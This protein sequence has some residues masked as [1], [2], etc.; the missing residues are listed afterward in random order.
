MRNQ[1]TRIC[2]DLLVVE[3]RLHHKRFCQSF[4]SRLERAPHGPVD[5]Q[6][7]E[8]VVNN[9]AESTRVNKIPCL[10]LRRSHDCQVYECENHTS[11]RL[12][13]CCLSPTACAA[14]P[15]VMQSL[16]SWVARP[17]N[18]A[19]LSQEL[20]SSEFRENLAF[21]LA[22]TE[23]QTRRPHGHLTGEHLE[24]TRRSSSWIASVVNG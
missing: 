21:L 3:Y 15:F 23:E 18:S 10:Q 6:G 8:W 22:S 16:T 4:W 7:R 12:H 11:T 2:R 9:N 20:A 24:Y 5:S 13:W 17:A 14:M 19:G 1:A